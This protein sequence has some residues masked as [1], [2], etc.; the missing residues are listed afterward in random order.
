MNNTTCP[1]CDTIFAGSA[2]PTCGYSAKQA[3]KDRAYLRA[4]CDFC[5]APWVAEWVDYVAGG[6]RYVCT[7]HRDPATWLADVRPRYLLDPDSLARTAK[8]P[9]V[10]VRGS[11]QT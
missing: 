11:G 10:Q 5:P 1:S 4:P 3:A 6:F 9:G 8:N 2:C 7:V